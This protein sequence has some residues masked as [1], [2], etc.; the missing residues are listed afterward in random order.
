MQAPQTKG[1]RTPSCGPQGGGRK[2]DQG[3]VTGKPAAIA[4]ASELHCGCPSR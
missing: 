1:P 4:V 2:K 3:S